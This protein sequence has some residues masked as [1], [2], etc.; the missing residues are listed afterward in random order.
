MGFY[1]TVVL[2]LNAN[3][4]GYK[5][6]LFDGENT[7]ESIRFNNSQICLRVKS[8]F[9][10]LIAYPL[11]SAYNSIL[12]YKLNLECKNLFDL[13]FRFNKITPRSFLNTFYL[14]DKTY[15][16]KID[17]TLTFTEA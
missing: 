4:L 2:R 13:Y 1:K 10:T 11:D 16:L 7:L 8:N 6:R 9:L 3:A 17:G 15:G 14:T 5:I 12:Y